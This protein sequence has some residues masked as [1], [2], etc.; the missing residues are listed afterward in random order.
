MREHRLRHGEQGGAVASRKVTIEGNCGRRC[1]AQATAWQ[2]K[3]TRGN[4]QRDIPW[5]TLSSFRRLPEI[6]GA[7]LFAA[8]QESLPEQSLAKQRSLSTFTLRENTRRSPHRP[9]RRS[10]FSAAAWLAF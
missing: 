5:G 1:L 6:A 3:K 2:K 4:R 9:G 7:S 8:R 10:A